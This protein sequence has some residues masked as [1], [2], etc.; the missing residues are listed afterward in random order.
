MENK[1]IP[2]TRPDRAS[3]APLTLAQRWRAARDGS[4][5]RMIAGVL[6]AALAI[7]GFLVWRA[8]PAEAPLSAA[9]IRS[10]SAPPAAD[11][12]RTSESSS[13]A[14]SAAPS[15]GASLVVDVVGP[16]RRP[17]I[18]SLPAGSR[19]ADAIAAAGGLARGRTDINLARLLADG[20]QVDVRAP[21][22]G[23]GDSAPAPASAGSATGGAPAAPGA[24][25]NLNTA[26]LAALEELPR[27]GPVTA[28]K[29]IEFRTQHNGFRSVEQLQEVSGIGDVTFAGLSSLV[30][31]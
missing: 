26:T 27:V 4:S 14:P 6:S 16:V 12:P 24:K 28:A 13:A 21:A 8:W 22:G 5:L 15:A 3:L 17:G 31:V 29:I 25:V 30:T 2:R 1:D 23:T 20:E 7:T 9:V 10:G 18:V 19:V 11:S